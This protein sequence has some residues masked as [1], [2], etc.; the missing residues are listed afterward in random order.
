MNPCEGMHQPLPQPGLLG[1]GA[2]GDA[3]GGQRL[4]IATDTGTAACGRR[5]AW[6]SWGWCRHRGRC[7]RSRVVRADLS[8]P[9]CWGYAKAAFSPTPIADGCG[10]G[11]PFC[12]ESAGDV[13]DWGRATRRLSLLV[14]WLSWGC[15]AVFSLGAQSLAGSRALSHAMFH[16]SRGLLS[17]LAAGSRSSMGSGWTLHYPD[18]TYYEVRAS[19]RVC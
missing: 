7:C 2:G 11:A 9:R 19:I 18:L 16:L 3:G 13:G 14:P 5:P 10:N 6:C 15:G 12:G 17:C 1:A 4:H 8:G